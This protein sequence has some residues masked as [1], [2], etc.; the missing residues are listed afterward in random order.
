MASANAV[1]RY[2]GKH[3]TRSRKVADEGFSVYAGDDAGTVFV[4]YTCGDELNRTL[5][6]EEQRQRI[7]G[8]IAKYTEHLAD[9]WHTEV[10]PKLHNMLVLSD[11][12]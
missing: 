10:H 12:A 3:F 4:H 9:R 7:A 6:G 11:R 5:N 1:S 8:V 2:M